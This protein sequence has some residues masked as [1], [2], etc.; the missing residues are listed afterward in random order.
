MTTQK[1]VLV[2]VVRVFEDRSAWCILGLDRHAASQGAWPF[3]VLEAIWVGAAVPRW[4]TRASK[5]VFRKPTGGA[6]V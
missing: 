4:P 3:G 2:S 1:G 6:R 5:S